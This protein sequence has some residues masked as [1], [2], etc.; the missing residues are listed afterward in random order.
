MKN[1]LPPHRSATAS[2]S[3]SVGLPP[4]VRPI[5]RA[6]SDLV[7]TAQRDPLHHGLAGQRAERVGQRLAGQ[8]LDVPV[9]AYHRQAGVLQLGGQ[10]RQ[11]RQRRYVRPVQVIDDD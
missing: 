3:G 8:H 6:T 11:Q 4:M 5:S 1:G 2:T 7:Q 9:G 10:E